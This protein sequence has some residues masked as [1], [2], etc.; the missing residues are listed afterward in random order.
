MRINQLVWQ[1]GS[2]AALISVIIS[3]VAY[4]I[5][6]E[7]LVGWQAGVAQAILIIATMIIVSR[8][9]RTNEGGFISFWRV[10]SH[11]MIAVLC[12]LFAS[13]LFN[14]LLFQVVNPNLLDV[15][16]DISLDKAEDMIKGFGLDDD[17]LK[18]T[19]KETEKAIRNGYTL[20]GSIKG[21][22]FGSI[23]W[24]LIALIVAATHY[25]IDNN[26]PNFN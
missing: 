8:A 24:G 5:G 17:I 13:A 19:M 2:M 22:I 21:V 7:L 18:E 1:H 23:F 4:I 3:L 26:K 12:I 16:L 20:A 10:F 11:I 9:I 15:I 14:V 6:V 25:K